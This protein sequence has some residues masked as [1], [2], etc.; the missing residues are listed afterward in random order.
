MSAFITVLYDDANPETYEGV[1]LSMTYRS[2]E[3]VF[4]TGAPFHDYLTAIFVVHE[5][6]GEDA[7]IM[8]SSSCDHF[9]M[10][11]GECLDA[12]NA[13][14]DQLVAAIKAA[15]EYVAA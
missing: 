11:G 3:E 10:D 12:E 8:G 9:V 14:E 13:T 15:R 6:W 1:S 2:P 4:N 7:I 5:R